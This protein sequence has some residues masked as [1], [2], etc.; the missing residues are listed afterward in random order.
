MPLLS[1]QASAPSPN[2]HVPRRLRPTRFAAHLLAIATIAAAVPAAARPGV[3]H[4]YVVLDQPTFDAMRTDPVVS[5]LLGA[6]DAGLPDYTPPP[7]ATDR[8]FLRGRRS[9]LELF[10]PKNRFDEPVG[11][12]G[13]AI[14]EDDDRRFDALAR[15]WQAFCP[16]RFSRATVAWTRRTPPVAWYNSIQCDDTATRSDLALWAMVYRPEFVRWQRPDLTRPSVRRAAVLAPRRGRFDITGIALAVPLAQRD[17]IARQFHAAGFVR[18]DAGAVTRLTGSGW[19]V[20]LHPGT[21]RIVLR[22]I[23]VRWTG[24]ATIDRALGSARLTSNR[25]GHATLSFATVRPDA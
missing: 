18:H 1:E 22:A 15:R 14:G 21:E 10:A 25:P 11:K 20:T 2:R 17:P 6:P 4:I 3:N 5:T 24:R 16:R 9:Y 13:I 7:A 19:T 12:V 23:D 8:V